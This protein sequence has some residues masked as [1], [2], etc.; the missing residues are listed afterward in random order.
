MKQKHRHYGYIVFIVLLAMIVAASLF[1]PQ[2]KSL[3][4]PSAARDY[5]L[6]FGIYGCIVFIFFLLLSIPLPIPSVPLVLA[7]GYIYGTII[8]STLSLIAVLIGASISFGLVRAYGRPALENMVD[9]HHLAHF[10]HTFKKRGIFAAFVSYTLPIFPSDCISAA[11]G[12]TRINYWTFFLVVALG[13]I[14]RF[15]IINSIGEDLL[16]GFTLKTAI[17]IATG[18]V[19]FIITIFREKIKHFFFEELKNRKKKAV[20]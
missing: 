9:E 15:L 13:H 11:L 12:L 7:G 14:P 5:V 6:G 2:L 18:S 16:T 20:A 10:N 8:G 4:S 19:L 17:V 3:S 1:F